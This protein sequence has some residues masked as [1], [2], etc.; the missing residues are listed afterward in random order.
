MYALFFDIIGLSSQFFDF[1]NFL[2]LHCCCYVGPGA[3]CG[4]YLSSL[5]TANNIWKSFLKYE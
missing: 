4:D 2:F 5:L 1:V 3:Q